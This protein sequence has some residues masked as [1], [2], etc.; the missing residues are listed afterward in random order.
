MMGSGACKMNDLC[1]VSQFGSK[2]GR[3]ES[4][5]V[6]GQVSLRDHTVVLAHQLK[7]VFGIYCLMGV[8]IGL[9]LHMNVSRCMIDKQTTTGKHL[10]IGRFSSGSEETAFSAAHEVVHG[11]SLTGNQVV[12]FQHTLA[13]TDN[14]RHFTRCRTLMLFAIKTSSTLGEVF[15]VT[16]SSV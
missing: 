11:D 8:Q 9:E 2:P 5:T 6:I 1:K 16:D 13:V 4:R 14:R 3:G 12:L 10:E 15:K 7:I